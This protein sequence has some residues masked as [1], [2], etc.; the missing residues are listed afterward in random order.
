MSKGTYQLRRDVDNL[1]RNFSSV[2]ENII[3]YE[4]LIKKT[5]EYKRTDDN[6][7][8]LFRGDC[9][10][11]NN[12]FESSASITSQTNNDFTV[13]G[14]F[15]TENDMVG[16]YWNSK[17]KITHPY[18]S[19]GSRT[20][21][22]DVILEF[23]YSMSGCMDFSDNSI[24]ITIRT[25]LGE[26]FYLAMNR[27]IEDNHFSFDFNN[28]T[29]LEGNTYIDRY[30][31]PV[32]VEEETPISPK[33]IES[34]MFVVVP[35]NYVENN[36]QY[37]IMENA[38]FTCTISNI[39]AFNA[40]LSYEHIALPPHPYRLCEGYDDFYDFN[41]KRIAR[42]MRKLGYVDWVDLYIG[43]SH[44]YEK[45]GTVGDIIDDLS[46]SHNRTE[47]MVLD[48][49][50]PLNNAFRAWLDCYSRE[51]RN[52]GTNNLIISVS[53]ENLQCP[54]SWRQKTADGRYALTGWIPSTF[55]YSP[56]H[57]EPI[58]YMKMVS[59]ACLDIIVANGQPPILQMGEA[60]WWWQESEVPNRP[61]CFYDDATKQK[62]YGEFQSNIPL[63]YSSADN[64]SKPVIRWLNK[65]L[66]EYSKQLRSVV[67]KP[68]Y[69]NGQYMAL[70]FPPS[71]TDV[72]RV[73]PMMREVN[74]L[75]DAYSPSQLDILQ[76]EDYDWVIWESPHH[77]EVYS[78]GQELGFPLERLHYYGGFVQY[79]DDAIEY[80]ILI[81]KAMDK[82]LRL[83]F[84]EVYVWAGTQVRRDWKMLGY[85]AYE[86][87]QGLLYM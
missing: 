7:Y 19:Y 2:W 65:Q 44:F 23:D 29:L 21:Y 68:K 54:T 55:F 70:F 42:E 82:A 71:V 8:W 73:P 4:E 48:Q 57:S 12:N 50:V 64:Y 83:K 63:Y 66:V 10:T 9:W 53:M 11:I 77:D 75:K 56:C 14:T 1:Q 18:I 76:L 28:M 34:I 47:K 85:D 16:L 22:S 58:A 69:N 62:Y 61:P 81:K 87:V 15:R 60:W 6:F 35:T 78:L 17:D 43:A 46:F 30:G 59:E 45:S 37:T 27:Y 51:L 38:Q 41:P 49:T 3:G 86:F 24:S 72:D 52:N 67:K 5:E 20:D 25:T 31:N 32:T 36:E 13:T 74:Y 80:W 79:T 26:T 40:L 84:A 33:N 39:Y